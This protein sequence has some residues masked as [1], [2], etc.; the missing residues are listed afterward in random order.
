MF[1]VDLLVRICV[2]PNV[3]CH[4]VDSLALAHVWR[5]RNEKDWRPHP[6]VQLSSRSIIANADQKT[7][8]VDI[9]GSKRIFLLC[10]LGI[11]SNQSIYVES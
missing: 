9:K 7:P 8:H 2:V 10:F 3:T 4:T 11:N 5:M 1:S 6:L